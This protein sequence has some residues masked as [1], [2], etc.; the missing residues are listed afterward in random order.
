MSDSGMVN[1]EGREDPVV[2]SVPQGRTVAKGVFR[3]LDGWAPALVPALARK[4]P[5][6]PFSPL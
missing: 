1:S 5:W 3:S 4:H 6:T 2:G